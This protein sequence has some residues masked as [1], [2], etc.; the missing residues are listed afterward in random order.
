MS[1]AMIQVS[2]AKLEHARISL[3]A[4]PGGLEN[5][6]KLTL[7]RV[8]EGLKTD[9]VQETKR[10]YHLL[11]KEIRSHMVYKR[12]KSEVSLTV[13]GKRKPISEYKV[14]GKAEDLKV[15]VR[16][17]GMKTLKTGFLIDRDGKKTVMYLPQG[18]GT[19]A[20]P[21]ISPSVPQAVGNKE[22]QKVMK[23]QAHE[24]FEKRLDHEIKRYLGV[25]K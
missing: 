18:E 3:A 8:G 19:K 7:G 15:A 20:M 22:T 11:P 4:I 2:S 13:T 23:K 1:K 16:T 25:L 10:K 9:A 24:R 5:A 17:D 12:T 14:Q 21:V 6:V